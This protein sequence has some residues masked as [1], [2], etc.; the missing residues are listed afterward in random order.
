[1]ERQARDRQ[2]HGVGAKGQTVAHRTAARIVILGR[3]V[4][5]LVGPRRRMV[6]GILVV[7]RARLGILPADDGRKKAEQG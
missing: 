4:G 5:V 3:I 1:M 2:N 6:L 7:V